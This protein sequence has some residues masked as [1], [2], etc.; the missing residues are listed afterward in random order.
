MQRRRFYAPPDDIIREAVMLSREE[1]HHLTRVLR[2]KPG[3]EALVFDGCG[4]EYRCN[5][6][7]VED[8]RALLEVIA[9]LRDRVESPIHFTLGQAL[10]KGEKFDLIVQKAT[11]LGVARMVPLL[12]ARTVV[13]PKAGG[14][15]P[16]RTRWQSI[17]LE[18]AQQSM[19]WDVPIVMAPADQLSFFSQKDK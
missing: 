15:N 19:R 5:I 11:E 9:E 1:T 13:R 7:K 2:L 6:V 14:A 10:V 8:S 17:A 12:T 18:A 16:P 3:S 4:R